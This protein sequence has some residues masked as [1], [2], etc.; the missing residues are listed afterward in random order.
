[1]KTDFIH[2][3]TDLRRENLSNFNLDYW[4][5]R[6]D[7]AVN[8]LDSLDN[9]EEKAIGM[10]G[11][12]SIYL[13]CIEVFFIN[14][15]ALPKS[16]DGYIKAIFISNKSLRSLIENEQM[17]GYKM[18]REF[19][20]VSIKPV[21]RGMSTNEGK[22]DED[23]RRYQNTMEEVV[24]DYLQDYEMLNAYKHGFRVDFKSG[25][26]TLSVGDG[27]IQTKIATMDSNINYIS[28]QA[29]YK[30]KTQ[31]IFQHQV[32]FNQDRLIGKAKFISYML[33]DL[34]SIGKY[35][36][37]DPKPELIAFRFFEIEDKSKWNNSYSSFRYKAPLLEGPL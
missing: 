23:I 6:V 4:S 25:E 33:A 13:Q 9:S 32:G 15:N 18:T 7:V 27:N 10:M 17:H 12:Y 24:K 21:L 2:N 19:L 14:L 29:D 22:V 20:N 3:G 26:S 37:A 5:N 30:N 11:L 8:E 34:M 31:V 35:S 1:M 28:K 16:S 36:F